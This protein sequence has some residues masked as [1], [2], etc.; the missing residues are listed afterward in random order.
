MK[1]FTPWLLLILVFLAG[2]VVGIVGTRAVVRHMIREAIEHPN[3]VRDAIERDLTRQL[4]LTADQEA[5]LHQILLHAHKQIRGL[6]EKFQPQLG[7]ILGD[8]EQ[9]INSILSPDQRERFRRLRQEHRALWQ[10]VKL[11]K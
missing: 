3:R 11:P 7:A 1:R 10:A 2:V 4:D 8:A 9:Q 6:R 5:K